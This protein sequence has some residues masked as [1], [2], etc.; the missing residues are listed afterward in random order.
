MNLE[1]QQTN[2]MPG[3]SNEDL[4]HHFLHISAVRVLFTLVQCLRDLS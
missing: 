4:A 3:I 1:A 2:K